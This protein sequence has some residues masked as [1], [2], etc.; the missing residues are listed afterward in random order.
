[1]TLY[2]NRAVSGLIQPRCQRLFS[3]VNINAWKHPCHRL[4]R[5]NSRVLTP[6]RFAS[7]C[8]IVSLAA[9]SCIASICC[10]CFEGFFAS[11]NSWSCS[12]LT[13]QVPGCNTKYRGAVHFIVDRCHVRDDLYY[14]RLL[15]VIPFSSV[16]RLCVCDNEWVAECI[17]STHQIAYQ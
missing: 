14:L 4:T 13:V 9:L 10:V 1:M 6:Q 2:H 8:G 12:H 5:S 7:F 15:F 16:L 3:G 17:S 11:Y